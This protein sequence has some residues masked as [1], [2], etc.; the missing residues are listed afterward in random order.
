MCVGVFKAINSD[1]RADVFLTTFILLSFFLLVLL[2]HDLTQEKCAVAACGAP[3][4]V[5][6]VAAVAHTTS[7]QWQ[8]PPGAAAAAAAA[9]AECTTALSFAPSRRSPT[10]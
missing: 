8:L 10:L 1:V 3:L 2:P 6:P 7:G 9:A 4:E 5:P